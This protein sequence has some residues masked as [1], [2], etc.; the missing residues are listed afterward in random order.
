[1]SGLF[2][3][4]N[5]ATSGLNASQIALQTSGH[6]ISNTTTDGYSRQRTNLQTTNPYTIT[7]VGQ[8]GTG[9][10]VKDITRVVD[11]FVRQQTREATSMSKFYEE[12]A[13]ALGQLEDYFGEPSD[14]ALLKQM[15]TIYD[16]WSKLSSNPELGTSKTLVVENSSTFTTTLNEMATNIDQLKSDVDTSVANSVYNLNQRIDELEVLNKKIVDN[17]LTAGTSN[18][19]LDQRDRLLKDI[20]TMADISTTFDKY[21]RVSELKVG[22][23]KI[24]DTDHRI[25]MSVV[26][27]SVNGST[28]IAVEGDRTK[29]VTIQSG[30]VN[31]GPLVVYNAE[32][33]KYDQITVSKG[34]IGGQLAASQEIK[35]RYQEFNQFVEKMATKMN[36]TYGDNGNNGPFF[37][38][39]SDSENIAKNIKVNASLQANPSK[40]MA[41]IGTNPNAGDG[42][43]AK[44]VALSFSAKDEQGMTYAEH[45][46]DIITKNGISKLKA[47]NTVKA[48]QT[49]LDQLENQDASISGVNINEEV[50]NVIR[51]SQAFQANARVLQTVSEML[52][53]LI[54]R[55]GA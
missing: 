50:S 41:G 39:G 24:L 31:G 17:S 54:N 2:G 44:N 15:N 37:D 23:T 25:P 43:L 27:S 21:G 32:T 34:Q 3:T 9:V 40:L 5:V 22:D 14:S 12:K 36:E 8:V 53:T 49:V 11:D 29:V 33:G 30:D 35:E 19:L 42:R 20:S 18:D 10:K 52:D 4:L 51:F 1:M 6:N 7:G 46:N 26:M 47:D 13:D 45:Y 48:Q 16:A 55:T 38:L 28:Q